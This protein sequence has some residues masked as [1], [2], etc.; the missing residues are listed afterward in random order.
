MDEFN[1][2]G[3][4]EYNPNMYGEQPQNFNEQ[5]TQFG[6]DPN[7]YGNQ[8]QYN[9]NM[10]QQPQES[11]GLSIA[12]MV[13]GILS[14]TCCCGAIGIFM[15]IAAII[16]GAI[17]KNKGGRGMAIAGI[18]CGSIGVVFGFLWTILSI[19]GTINLEQYL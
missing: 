19:T 8:N 11:K 16:M 17:G 4:Q 10:N 18:I 9:P 13:L 3:Q 2:N 6:G 7:M 12:S 14:C 1:N 15:G 5:P